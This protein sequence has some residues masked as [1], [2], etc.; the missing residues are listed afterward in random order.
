MQDGHPQTTPLAASFSIW[1]AGDSKMRSVHSGFW[2]DL[3]K[4]PSTE[5]VKGLHIQSTG[6]ELLLRVSDGSPLLITGSGIP[7]RGERGSWVQA[8]E[9]GWPDGHWRAVT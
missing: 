9:E 8:V 2:D 3:K 5:G 4:M 1:I 7:I 6:L